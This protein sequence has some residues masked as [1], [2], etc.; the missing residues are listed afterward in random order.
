MCL[1]LCVRECIFNFLK[2]SF[3]LYFILFYFVLFYLFNL[4]ENLEQKF[5]DNTSLAMCVNFCGSFILIEWI[6]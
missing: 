6:D 1:I 2:F 3:I 4:N 5:L